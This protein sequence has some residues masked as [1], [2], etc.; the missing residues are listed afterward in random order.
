MSPGVAGLLGFGY[1]NDFRAPSYYVISNVTLALERIHRMKIQA[2]MLPILVFKISLQ[3]E[4][5]LLKIVIAFYKRD[6]GGRIAIFYRF[7]QSL[8]MFRNFV[9]N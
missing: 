1:T 8:V 9:K 5:T 4:M 6:I 3:R 2:P 7:L